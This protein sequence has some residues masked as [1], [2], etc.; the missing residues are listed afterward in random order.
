MFGK[1]TKKQIS[2]V[3][4]SLS[5]F[6]GAMDFAIVNTALPA[7]QQNLVLSNGQL[8]WV[9]NIFSLVHC[10]LLVTM[11]RLADIIGHRLIFYTG[12][13]LFGVSSLF[14]GLAINAFGLILFRGIQGLGGAMIMPSVLAMITHM[15]APE[16]RG[17]AIGLWSSVTAVGLAISPALGG[18]LV[19][20]L[21]WHWVFF[22][23]LPIVVICITICSL[24]LEKTPRYAQST[25]DWLGFILLTTSIASLVTAI[26]QSATWGWGSGAVL[27]LFG[28]SFVTGFSFIQVEKSVENPILDLKLF[29]NKPFFAAALSSFINNYFSYAIL[30]LLPLYLHE[31]LNKNT[32]RWSFDSGLQRSDVGFMVDRISYFNSNVQLVK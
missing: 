22:I 23:N 11:G 13:I 30:F 15:T 27:V 19:A 5:S 20:L 24:A 6:M 14:A 4:I 10:A 29:A 18:I 17:K 7:I 3:G 9:M 8:Q 26:V 2:L 16:E 12:V 1:I 31:I 21:N 32:I 25:I 28:V